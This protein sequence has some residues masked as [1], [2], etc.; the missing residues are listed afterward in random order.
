MRAI[1]AT[2]ARGVIRPKVNPTPAII[3]VDAAIT[4]CCFAHFI[5]MLENHE[6]VPA[7]PL[8]LFIPWYAID[9][10]IE[11]RKMAIVASILFMLEL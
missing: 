7:I 1:T 2:Q 6:V 3:S 11:I 9:V 8:A 5:P 4:A 10:P